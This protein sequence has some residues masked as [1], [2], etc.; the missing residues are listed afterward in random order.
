[1]ES[2]CKTTRGNTG[3]TALDKYPMMILQG[4]STGHT[5]VCI[6]MTCKPGFGKQII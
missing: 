4:N 3:I 1:M 6:C 2:K 5:G